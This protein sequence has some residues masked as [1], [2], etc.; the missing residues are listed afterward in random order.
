MATCLW[1]VQ[2]LSPSLAVLF[3][4]LRVPIL[5]PSQ[6]S[7]LLSFVSGGSPGGLS[8]ASAGALPPGPSVLLMLHLPA[9]T[10][11]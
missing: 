2:A 6:P 10:L 3:S 9:P 4:S 11:T 8:P 7:F 5:D 1:D